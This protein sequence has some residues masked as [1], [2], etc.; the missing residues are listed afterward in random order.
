MLW[1]LSTRNTGSSGTSVFLLDVSC[2]YQCYHCVSCIYQCYLVHSAYNPARRISGS[3]LY[4][5][6]GNSS[7]FNKEINLRS[8]VY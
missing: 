5:S 8:N 1:C 2:I 6:I 4:V 7:F 3:F